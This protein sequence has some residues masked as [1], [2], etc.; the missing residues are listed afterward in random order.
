MKTFT[1]YQV[2]L[3]RDPQSEYAK[4]N[5]TVGEVYT[6]RD[7]AGCC[8]VV[9]TDIPGDTTIINPCWLVRV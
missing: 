2:K 1:P 5:M 8:V 9:T 4:A 6:V 3:V 7:I